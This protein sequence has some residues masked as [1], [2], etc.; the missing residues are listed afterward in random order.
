MAA[1]SVQVLSSVAHLPSPG[2]ASTGSAG[3]STVKVAAHAA[4]DPMVTVQ[5][6]IHTRSH[7]RTRHLRCW[8]AV[9]R[10]SFRIGCVQS[11]GGSGFTPQVNGNGLCTAE[12]AEDAEDRRGGVEPAVPRGAIPLPPIGDQ[13]Q[14]RPIPRLRSAD[15]CVLCVPCG[16]KGRYRRPG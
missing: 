14:A 8:F 15:L 10:L 7:L 9:R 1:R 16:E 12:D 6:L 13:L 2:F 3:L 5:A 4:C 11:M